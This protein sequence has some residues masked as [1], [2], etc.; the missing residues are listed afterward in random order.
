VANCV[1]KCL[2]SSQKK[3]NWSKEVA[4]IWEHRTVRCA[5]NCVWCP[6]W[7][8]VN[9]PL[10]GCSWGRCGYK[11]PDWPVRQPR[12]W[13]TVGRIVSVSH[14]SQVNGHQVALDWP[15]RHRTLR[16]AKWSKGSNGRL[17][18]TPTVDWRGRHR[19]VNSALSC[20]HRTVWCALW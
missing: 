17:L 15:V 20:V 7:L 5:P 3:T 12:A 6:G 16:C 1:S 18:Q 13:P 9:N 2:G 4:P 10:S 11:S 19:T 8:S 14:V